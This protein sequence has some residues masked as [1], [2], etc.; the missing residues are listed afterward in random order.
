MKEIIIDHTNAGSRLDKIVSKYLD[1]APK[2]FV[3]KMLRKKNIILND[4]K[5]S[6]NELLTAGDVIKI[7]LADATVAKF[8]GEKKERKSSFSQEDIKSLICYEDE[9]IIAFNKP[10]GMLSQRANAGDI[11]LND[12]LLAYLD[13]EETELFTP[14]IANRLDRNTSGIVL[15]GKTLAASRCL[16]E[17]IRRRLL[18]K[19]YV[20]LVKG[21][22]KDAETIDGYLIKDEDTNCVQIL[23]DASLNAKRIVTAYEP[24]CHNDHVTLLDVDLITGKSH[25]IRSHLAYISHPII[26]DVKYGDRSINSR[27]LAEYGLKWQLLHAYKVT[28]DHADGELS[29]L[30]GKTIYA[31]YPDEFREIIEGENLWLPGTAED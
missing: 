29:Y 14:G 22:M 24:L 6:G 11:S 27:Y 30:N 26:G 3:Y 21:V 7:Y 10:Q 16:N 19:H 20:C 9:N 12:L 13:E 17:I 1:K 15:A 2:S 5:A 18:S 23:Q 25:Q 8:K 28:F 31:E 4:K